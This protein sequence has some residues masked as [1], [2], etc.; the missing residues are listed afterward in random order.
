[1]NAKKTKALQKVNSCKDYLVTMD[2]AVV[3]SA[4]ALS[5]IQKRLVMSA[6]SKLNPK[7]KTLPNTPIKIC[8]KEYSETF[9]VSL[10]HSYDDL[11][12]ACDEILSTCITRYEPTKR[13]GVYITA[14][15][16]WLSVAKYHEKE[17]W[18]SIEFN[19][20]IKPYITGLYKQFTKYKLARAGSLRS[21]YAWRFLEYFEMFSRTGEWRITIDEFHHCLEIPPSFKSQFGMIRTRIIEPA[22]KE[23]QEKDGWLIEWQPIKTGRKVTSLYFKFVRNP[24]GKLF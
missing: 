23:L 16:N 24:Q 6:L 8:A 14:K 19:E 15:Y 3:R 10:N 1:M 20:K 7:S 22:M 5:L 2:N 11:K 13:E 9:G 21:L 12:R 18:V 4:Q 17:G